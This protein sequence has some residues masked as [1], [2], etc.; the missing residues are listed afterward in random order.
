MFYKTGIDITND[1][2]MFEFLKNHFTY[3]TMNS[4]N[5]Q[6]SIANVAK[7]NRL[8]LTGDWWIALKLLESGEYETLEYMISDWMYAHTGY[9]VY[10]NG[11]SGGYLVLKDDSC[12][13]NILPESII[14]SDSYEE[15][16]EW[17][18]ENYGSVKANRDELVK[19]TK[20]VRD[21]DRLCDELREYCDRLSNS[22]FEQIEMMKAV[23][24]FNDQ[25]YDD[26]E[27]LGYKQLHCDDAG[28]VDVS[29]IRTFTCLWEA[30]LRVADRSDYGY[31]IKVDEDDIARY[32]SR[33]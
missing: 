11:R 4:W 19:Y 18:R 23:E 6:Y 22:S 15:Y 33:V 5:R 3:P 24:L 30:F 20:L 12:Y 17:C 1:R 7:M 2:Q 8:G 27:L 14:D 29:E 25:Y 26:L 9:S 31:G 32:E 10:F 21:F 13:S 28:K 16:K